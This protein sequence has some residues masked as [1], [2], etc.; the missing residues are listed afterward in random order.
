MEE[1]IS[2]KEEKINFIKKNVIERKLNPDIIIDFLRSKNITNIN[3]CSLS[4]LNQL[5]DLIYNANNSN[6]EKNSDPISKINDKIEKK[7]KKEKKYKKENDERFG[8]VISDFINCKKNEVTCLEKYEKIE[9]KIEVNKKVEKGIFSSGQIIFTFNIKTEPLNFF[10]NRKYVDFYWLREKLQIIYSTNILPEIQDIDYRFEES[11]EEKHERAKRIFQKFFD[12][13]LKDPLIKTSEILY[14][15]LSIEKDSDFKKKKLEYDKIKAPI[16]IKNFKFI[17]GQVRININKKKE[18]YFEIINDSI[19]SNQIIL[20][21]INRNFV[22]LKNKMN[23]IINIYL[24]FIPLF[25]KL[26][27]INEKYGEHVINVESYKLIK[28][29]FEL[30]SKILKQQNSFFFVDINEYMNFI[31][32][33]INYLKHLAQNTKNQ[34]NIYYES[35]EKLLAK[36]REL[37][38]KKDTKNWNLSGDD[39][40]NLPKFKKNKE[41]AYKKIEYA[42]TYYV[43]NMKEK[44]GFYLNRLITEYERLRYIYANNNKNIII[45]FAMK[46][47]NIFL[48]YIQFMREIMGKMDQC[49]VP[50]V[51]D[52][53]KFFEMNNEINNY[54]DNQ[55]EVS[56][57]K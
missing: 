11:P 51:N 40:D 10:V 3:F 54:D 46:Q 25:E 2:N 24:S 44:Y 13:I 33:N 34:E 18:E 4:D 31:S 37:F 49:Y 14:D 8:V 15:F 1:D 27:N 16:E 45:L 23:D 32:R 6:V 20:D 56:Y 28:F 26:I 9:I 52:T 7:E 29:I 12:F 50:E 41:I 57:N 30:W 35:S 19:E 53:E 5:I 36:K 17:D 47:Q 39:I 21:E 42:N 43:V 38:K 48:E 55:S 22:K